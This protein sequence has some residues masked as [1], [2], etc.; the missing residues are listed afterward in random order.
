MSSNSSRL[1]SAASFVVLAC[2]CATATSA[3]TPS[4]TLGD[5]KDAPAYVCACSI[6]ND[7]SGVFTP[8]ITVADRKRAAIADAQVE[9][10]FFD[11]SNN[12]LGDVV[13]APPYGP[14]GLPF[15]A[16]D[17]AVCRVKSAHFVDGSTY[18]TKASQGGSSLAPVAGAVLGAGAAALLLGANHG[19]KNAASATSAPSAVA[20]S[21]VTPTPAPVGTI[22]QLARPK[23]PGK[24]H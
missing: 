11:A 19:S 3:G 24:P 7:S 18:E 15:G 21:R 9:L 1:R 16:V 23:G 14:E 22:E 4:A 17:R 13:V 20:S 6:E 10:D 2:A 8:D 5:P 12:L